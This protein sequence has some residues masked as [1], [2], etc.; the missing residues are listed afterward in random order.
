MTRP[1]MHT[2]YEMLL[3]YWSSAVL[4]NSDLKDQWKK[5]QGLIDAIRYYDREYG[6]EYNSV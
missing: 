1:V 6:Q 4:N 3:T 2:H 5:N